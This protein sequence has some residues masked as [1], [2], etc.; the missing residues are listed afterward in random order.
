MYS[1]EVD[2]TLPGLPISVSLAVFCDSIYVEG[3]LDMWEQ[4][5]SDEE[6]VFLEHL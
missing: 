5:G 1:S 6:P 4:E 2:A 3:R